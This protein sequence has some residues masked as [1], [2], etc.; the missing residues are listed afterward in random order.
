LTKLRIGDVG[1][2]VVRIARIARIDSRSRLFG[3]PDAHQDLS[4]FAEF[5]SLRNETEPSKIHVGTRDHRNKSLASANQAIADNMCLETGE[6]KGSCWLWNR[7]GLCRR[8]L[9]ITR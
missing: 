1:C 4:T 7:S 5:G 2:P 8:S 3:D 9:L 6:S